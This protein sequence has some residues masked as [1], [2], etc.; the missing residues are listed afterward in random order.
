MPVPIVGMLSEVNQRS[1]SPGISGVF[2]GGPGIICAIGPSLISSAGGG[3]PISSRV[4]RISSRRLALRRLSP[5]HRTALVETYYRGRPYEAVAADLG[6]PVGTV[7]S[8]VYYALRQLR[9]AL[10][11]LGWTDDG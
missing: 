6:I 4:L 2:A 5:D 8:R 3:Q 11:E 10:E 7:K 9:L 1:G